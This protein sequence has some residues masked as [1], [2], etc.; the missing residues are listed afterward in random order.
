MTFIW[1][2]HAAASSSNGNSFMNGLDAKTL[3]QGL[4]RQNLGISP[5]ENMIA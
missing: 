1:N 2:F 4:P 5:H 3:I